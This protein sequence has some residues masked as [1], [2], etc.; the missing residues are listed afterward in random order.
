MV[1]HSPVK[2]ALLGS[3]TVKRRNAAKAACKIGPKFCPDLIEALRVELNKNYWKTQVEI[4][5]SLGVLGCSSASLILRQLIEQLSHEENS[6]VA[7]VAATALIRVTRK[8]LADVECVEAVLRKS[9]YSVAEGVFNAIGYDRMVFDDA[10]CSRILSQYKDFG[11]DRL[12]GLTDP[13]YGLAAACAGWNAS[14]TKDFLDKCI[15]E[16]DVPLT[17]VAENSLCQKYVRLR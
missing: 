12:R 3:S 15:R 17:Y 2:H 1:D 10:F 5:R 16:G 14:V 9:T 7:S 8:S 11:A 4:A 6:Q 13:R